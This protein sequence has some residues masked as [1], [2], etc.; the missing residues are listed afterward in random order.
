[1]E[2]Y[3]IVFILFALFA[4]RKEKILDFSS[5]LLASCLYIICYGIVPLVILWVDVPNTYTGSM[6]NI[7]YEPIIHKYRYFNASTLAFIS[8]LFFWFG[9][10]VSTFKKKALFHTYLDSHN[11]KKLFKITKWIFL[12]GTAFLV[13]YIML[14]GSISNMLLA[15]KRMAYGGE[16]EV[17]VDSPYLFLIILAK[18]V[19]FSSYMFWGLKHVKDIKLKKYFYISLL[20][21][22]FIL[23]RFFGRMILMTF[24]AIFMLFDFIF[25]QKLPKLKFVILAALGGFVILFGN[26]VFKSFLYEDA[27]S[28]RQEYY[29]NADPI[30]TPFLDI[31]GGFSFP[32]RNLLH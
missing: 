26:A 1:M 22:L 31:I 24:I 25:K 5:F 12:S 14:F 4:I 15:N 6:G 17:E 27:F 29:S 3:I 32:Y 18:I 7:A 11:V 20:I 8:Y 19:I 28:R 23:F 21:S 10:R 30:L 13:L 16:A 9:Y 2:Y